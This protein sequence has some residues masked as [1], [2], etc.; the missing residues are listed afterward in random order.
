MITAD[1]ATI[2]E[3]LAAEFVELPSRFLKLSKHL[4]AS[5]F[6]LLS[7]S[8]YLDSLVIS[9]QQLNGQKTGRFTAVIIS[10]NEK[11][12]TKICRPSEQGGPLSLSK[13]T[14]AEIIALYASPRIA[15]IYIISI[16]HFLGEIIQT[17]LFEIFEKIRSTFLLCVL[18][19]HYCN[20]LLK[21]KLQCF[22]FTDTWG[23]ELMKH[24]L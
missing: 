16:A 20:A 24:R 13:I 5:L 10:E 8:F 21:I 11:F 1:L 4:C 6:L 14:S 15:R 9:Y 12:I 19:N 23:S 3:R 22:L 17:I 2:I 18:K 7:L